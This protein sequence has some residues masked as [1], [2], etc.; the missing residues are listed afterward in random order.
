MSSLP[1]EPRPEQVALQLRDT[2]PGHPCTQT[3]QQVE[4]PLSDAQFDQI[5]RGTELA[6]SIEKAVRYAHFSGWTTLLAGVVSIPFAFGNTPMLIFTVAL[7]GVGTRELTLRRSLK[8]L[9]QSAPKK[10]AINQLV[11]GGLLILY[12]IFMLVSAPAQTMVESAMQKDPMMSSTP[13]ISGMMD[14]MVVL[15]RFATAMMYVGM[16]VLAVFFQGGTALY[17]YRK[18]GKLKKLHAQTP[19]WVV[20]VYQVVHR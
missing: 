14:D 5:R 15:E 10:L 18:G 4:S 12:A 13:E 20:R 19:D 17:Y 3:D 8:V 6:K 2:D 11:L 7:A 16:I 9:D 1:T